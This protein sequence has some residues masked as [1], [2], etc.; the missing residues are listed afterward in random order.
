MK[1]ENGGA[2]NNILMIFENV[3]T[4]PHEWHINDY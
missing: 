4:G 1:V 2:G 3:I